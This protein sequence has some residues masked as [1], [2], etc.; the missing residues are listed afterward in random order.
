MKDMYI[1]S[2]FN[3]ECLYQLG[4]CENVNVTLT[5]LFCYV[6]FSADGTFFFFSEVNFTYCF[7]LVF[8]KNLSLWEWNLRCLIPLSHYYNQDE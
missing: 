3:R 6:L 7:I 8:V 4:K 1:I 5:L 2:I